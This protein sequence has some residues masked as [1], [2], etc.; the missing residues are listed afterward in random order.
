MRRVGLLVLLIL[1]L[2]FGAR[3]QK[4]ANSVSGDGANTGAAA[5][6]FASARAPRPGGA[7]GDLPL[8]FEKNRGQA[9]SPVKYLARGRGYI[10]FLTQQ[11]TVLALRHPWPAAKQKPAANA[12][13]VPPGLKHE[14]M[15][16][17]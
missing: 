12:A 9:D 2:V 11:E 5:H 10:L 7:Y 1:S 3:A 8:S 16:M 6:D 14:T 17:A 15:Q 4:A 13:A